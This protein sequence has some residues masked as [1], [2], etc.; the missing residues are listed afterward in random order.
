MI[1][2]HKSIRYNRSF[3]HYYDT[4]FNH[5][6][7]V[8]GIFEMR[9]SINAYIIPDPYVFIEDGIFFFFSVTHTQQGYPFFGIGSD[10]REGFLKVT[11]Y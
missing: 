7:R 8:V 2:D 9:A 11:A 10:I 4:I 5:I 3:L 6:E 1:S